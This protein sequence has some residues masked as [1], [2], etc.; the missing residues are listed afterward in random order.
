MATVSRSSP[1]VEELRQLYDRSEHEALV[2]RSDHIQK[3]KRVEDDDAKVILDLSRAF[4][5]IHLGRF[6]EASSALEAVSAA[7]PASFSS[8]LLYARL[9]LAW[10]S[11]THVTKAVDDIALLH[12][13]DAERLH[14][15]LLYRGGLYTS[16][17]DRYK[18]LLDSARATLEE[19]KKP[20]ALSL[21]RL[22]SV[23]GR[24]KSTPA[25]VTSAEVQQFS[26]LVNELGTNAMASLILAGKTK[27]AFDVKQHLRP[28]YELEYNAACGMIANSDYTNAEIALEKAEALLRA[29]LY[30]E[31]DDIEE[32]MSPIKVQKA[33]LQHLAGDTISA[34][35]C[36]ADIIEEEK[37]DAASLAVAANNL[38]V[39]QAQLAV[40]SHESKEQSSADVTGGKPS[41]KDHNAVIEGLKQMRA[42]S[43]RD[44]ERKLTISQ[45]RTMARNRAILL[46]QTGRLDACR[47]ELSR[48]KSD[49]PDDEAISLIEASVAARDGSLKS[50][51]NILK[52]AGDNPMFQAAR[53]QIAVA[54][55][56][57]ER[58]AGILQEL[59]PGRPAALMT[60]ATLLEECG[61]VQGAVSVLNNLVK[62]SA[63]ADSWQA[64][65][66]LAGTLLR[67][68]MFQ[69]A[70]DT[71]KQ[72]CQER[73]DDDVARA[74]LVVAT[75]HCDANEALQVMSSL[76]ST[77]STVPE[78]DVAKLEAMP[79]PKRRALNYRKPDGVQVAQRNSKDV[80]A[81]AE[82]SRERRKKKK[83][84]R[85]PKN[86]D[87]S[88]PP[89][90]P[91]RWLPK[92]LRSN[93]RKKK[94]RVEPNQFRGSQGADAD[95]AEAAAIK[96]AEKAAAK[97]TAG[98]SEAPHGV[99]GRAK[100]QRKRRNRR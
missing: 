3:R 68:G 79:P 85:L 22:T 65:K 11:N 94:N 52:S 83:K 81:R 64:R 40:G 9:Y 4:S 1:Y 23:T 44:V 10:A 12:G 33:Y 95:A 56:E 18:S 54:H 6:S 55:G 35:R 21:W 2:T 47:S 89:P 96:N 69:Q 48:V 34:K 84:K 26:D 36:Y 63:K 20:A 91:E 50:A 58:A 38:S 75:S 14:L 90:D 60:A 76:P 51:D 15:Q 72:V 93:Y 24:T 31:D 53:V 92:T 43:N 78:A 39:A 13:Q 62:K 41:P 87:P 98:A 7:K 82:A 73:P 28:T 100:A 19:T 46:V 71:L 25:P 57:K 86:Y 45:R 27:E 32:A 97:A 88:G 37:A 30:E 99:S 17:S 5:L 16:A 74:H 29:E 49:F 59:F 42:T 8:Q 77:V 67:A 80:A 61:D 66:A 70:A